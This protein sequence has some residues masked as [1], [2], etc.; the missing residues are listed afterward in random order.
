MSARDTLVDRYIAARIAARQA[1]D[2]DAFLCH[3]AEASS[4]QDELR[5]LLDVE[6]DSVLGSYRHSYSL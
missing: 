2:A 1:V 3:A 6:P 4:V 5:N